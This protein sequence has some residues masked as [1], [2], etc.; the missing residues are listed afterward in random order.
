MANEQPAAAPFQLV[1]LS[2]SAR[3]GSH[4]RKAVAIAAEAAAKTGG[5]VTWVDL[6]QWKLPHFDDT[7][8]TKAA[9]EVVRLREVVKAADA[10][11]IGTPVYHD[12]LGGA[13]KNALDFLYQP[14]LQDKVTALIAVGG[15]RLGQHQALEHLRAVLRE[16]GAWTLPRQV[17]VPS[18]D[19]AF[20]EQGQA[21]DKEI[22]MRLR[23]LGQELML[24]CR[25]LRPKRR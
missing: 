25:Q 21:K 4:T 1:A 17:A 18:A 12:S 11:L 2:G 7:L 10:L 13:L 19:D 8:E 23:V 16:T 6:A 22:D 3:P 5:A 20:D 9:P 15:G 14:E 24:R